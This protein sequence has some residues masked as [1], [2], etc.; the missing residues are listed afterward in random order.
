METEDVEKYV[1]AI[2]ISAKMEY[3][4]YF[5]ADEGLVEGFLGGGGVGKEGASSSVLP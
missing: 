1:K 4:E 5:V 3:S 2:T